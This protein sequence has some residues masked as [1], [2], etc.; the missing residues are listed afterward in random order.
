M[1]TNL[2]VRQLDILSHLGEVGAQTRGELILALGT[3]SGTLSKTLVALYFRRL[4]IQE[5]DNYLLSPL[6]R[7]LLNVK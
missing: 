3:P 1:G 5:G 2:G 7:R 6:G 4:I